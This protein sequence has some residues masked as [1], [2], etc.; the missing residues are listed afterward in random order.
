MTKA[1]AMEKASPEGIE[2]IFCAHYQRV[3]RTIGRIIIDQARAEELAV[4]V[5]LRWWRTP[6]AQ[7]EHAEGWLYRTAIRMALDELR[8]RARQTRFEH[9]LHVFHPSPS[10]PEEQYTA[11]A[12]QKH[13]RAV[14]NLLQRRHAEILLLWSE[15][16]SHREIASVL[17]MN[18]SYVGSLISRAQ[19]VFRKEYVKRYGPKS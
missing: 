18:L 10:T 4:E 14:L 15:G 6:R 16:F 12:E 5:F 3:T 11:T 2:A 13:V 8:R 1:G 17:A 9:L 19:E 7:G